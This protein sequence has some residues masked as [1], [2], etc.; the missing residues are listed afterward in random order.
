M[1]ILPD[2]SQ[3]YFANSRVVLFILE[4]VEEVAQDASIDLSCN[5]TDFASIMALV[6]GIHTI[7]DELL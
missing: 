4:V 3:C 6:I 7:H 5:S 1:L 2:I